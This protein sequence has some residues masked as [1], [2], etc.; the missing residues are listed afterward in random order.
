MPGGRQE[1][2]VI[3][4]SG[5]TFAASRDARLDVNEGG[6]PQLRHKLNSICRL[7]FMPL[8]E[9]T[10]LEANASLSMSSM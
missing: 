3:N 5:R 4:E 1:K 6:V 10:F 8:A 9:A 7:V 2:C